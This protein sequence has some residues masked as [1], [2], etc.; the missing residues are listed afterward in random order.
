[1]K[2]KSGLSKKVSS[3][4][5]ELHQPDN[6]SAPI[7]DKDA[8]GVSDVGISKDSPVSGDNRHSVK[9]SY[10]S[11]GFPA[12]KSS[13]PLTEDQEYA[14]S[15]RKKLFFVIGLS[16]VLVLVLFL[17][18]YQPANK[19]TEDQALPSVPTIAMKASEIYW[20]DPGL[21]SADTRDPMIFEESAAKL[22]VVESKME[23]LVLRGIVHKPQGGSTALIG[24]DIYNEGDEV[25]GWTITE[26][27]PN[28]VKL[29]KSDDEKMELKMEDR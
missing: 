18:F 7:A 2:G 25:D 20:P 12:Q 1:M 13:A 4:F 23:G 17:N 16:I 5:G 6:P 24:T 29:Q 28:L 3:I 8:L 21:W 15:Q 10:Q 11:S 26:I 27:Y 14:T 22:S 19:P 9:Q